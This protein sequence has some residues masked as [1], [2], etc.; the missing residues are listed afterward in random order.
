MQKVLMIGG[1]AALQ[2]I[3]RD[4]LVKQNVLLIDAITGKEALDK[5]YKESP[6]GI[7]LDIMLPGGMN[8]FDVAGQL[9]KDPRYSEIPMII[10]TNLDSASERKTAMEMGINDYLVKANVSTEEVVAKITKLLG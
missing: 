1:D 6:D 3:Y 9:K 8:G 4:A 5:V 7:I 10:L 2:Q